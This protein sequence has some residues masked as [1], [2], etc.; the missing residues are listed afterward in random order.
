MTCKLICISYWCVLHD[1]RA[2]GD[3]DGAE[4]VSSFQIHANTRWRA[5]AD[6]IDESG[7]IMIELTRRYWAGL[8]RLGRLPKAHWLLPFLFID[9]L[10]SWVRTQ[11]GSSAPP[12]Y[13]RSSSLAIGVEIKLVGPETSIVG[14]RA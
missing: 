10:V 14:S 13:F 7:G 11:T 8:E 12:R 9:V 6:D 4:P 5:L 3:S 1:L 2:F